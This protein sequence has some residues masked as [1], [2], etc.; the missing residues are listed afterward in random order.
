MNKKIR[1]IAE[2]NEITLAFIVFALAVMV[3]GVTMFYSGMQFYGCEHSYGLVISDFSQNTI[4]NG[5]M[6]IV[7]GLLL[8]VLA[9]LTLRPHVSIKIMKTIC[10]VNAAILVIAGVCFMKEILVGSGAF[11]MTVTAAGTVMCGILLAI[12]WYAKNTLINMNNRRKFRNKDN[13]NVILKMVG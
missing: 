4:T 6:F 2:V 5:A 13:S 9:G 12:F 8:M 7:D 3:L 11:E 10:Y 1:S